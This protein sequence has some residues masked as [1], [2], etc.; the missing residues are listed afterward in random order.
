MPLTSVALSGDGSLAFVATRGT[1]TTGNRI[2][3][4]S[5]AT[6]ALVWQQTGDGDFQ[7]VDVSGS[8]VYTGG[9]FT[10][11]AGQVRGHLAAFDQHTGAI[12]PWAPT[13]SGV[14]GVLDLQVTANSILVA[15]QFHKVSGVVAQGVARFHSD[16]TDPPPNTPPT[17]AGPP[18][19]DTTATT[20]PG[21]TPP[22]TVP[23][24]NGG[25]GGGG[26]TTPTTGS[27]I[28]K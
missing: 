27:A 17:T 15:G 13:I 1:N 11:V 10:T 16:G 19:T 20:V 4:W 22:A 7:A 5:T 14:H 18:T 25:G 28:L 3:A 21:G 8:L 24:G 12:Q 23:A 6:G 26:G 9:H 2:Q